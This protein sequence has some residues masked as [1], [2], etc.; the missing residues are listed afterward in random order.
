[1]PLQSLFCLLSFSDLK[2]TCLGAAQKQ[3]HE[4]I[5]H[6]LPWKLHCSFAALERNTWLMSSLHVSRPELLVL[7]QGKRGATLKNKSISFYLLQA[8]QSICHHCSKFCLSSD[9][10]VFLTFSFI[11][12]IWESLLPTSQRRIFKKYIEEPCFHKTH[13]LSSMYF[14]SVPQVVAISLQSF[15]NQS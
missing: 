11:S 12:C 15:A 2:Y 4:A 8:R 7:F 10:W 6:R 3:F 14:S 1:M 5:V 9:F 13:G